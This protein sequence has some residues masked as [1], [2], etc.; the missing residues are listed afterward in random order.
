MKKDLTEIVILLDRSGSMQSVRGDVIGGFNRF[1]EEQ[2]QIPGE[3]LLSLVQFDS[4]GPH[5]VVYDRVPL[6]DVPALTEASYVPRRW[7]PLLDAM[8][9]TITEAGRK[10]ATLPEEER[11]ETVIFV[12]ATDGMENASCE[13][14][15]AA[16]A[17]SVKTQQ[18][19]FRW[20]F[21]Y[22][23]ANQNAFVEA[24]SFGIS[25]S[26]AAGNVCSYASTAHMATR[27]F[28]DATKATTYY[29]THQDP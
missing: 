22:L 19:Q 16:V 27:M 24:G 3:A 20:R 29:R 1:V 9:W 14:S 15:K 10:L 21:V 25:M 18:E 28:G 6:R 4:E 11:P 23:G 7:T 2:K 17:A 8:G 26:L 5:D 12:V 13:F